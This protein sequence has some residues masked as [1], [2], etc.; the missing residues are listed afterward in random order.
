MRAIE[1]LDVDCDIRRDFEREGGG[2]GTRWSFL[3]ASL[4]YHKLPGSS[5]TWKLVGDELCTMKAR[6]HPCGRTWE[7]T[8]VARQILKADVKRY[9]RMNEDVDNTG[10]EFYDAEEQ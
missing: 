4:L 5:M 9:R 6:A 8:L 1:P 7:M 10:E 2:K 3:K